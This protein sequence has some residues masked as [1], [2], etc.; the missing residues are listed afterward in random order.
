MSLAQKLDQIRAG[1]EKN[2]PAPS[3]EL[4][5]RATAELEASGQL[6]NLI[7]V[8]AKLPAFEMNNQ[9]GETVSHAELL[10]DGPLV[11]TVYRGL[12]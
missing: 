2:I 10:S 8:G 7:P 4:M 11:M 3:L 12:W 5:H 6:D 9:F 1:A